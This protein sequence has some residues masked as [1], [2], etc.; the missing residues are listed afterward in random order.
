MTDASAQ[1]ADF[2]PF[3]RTIDALNK[4]SRTIQDERRKAGEA[5][6]ADFDM[7]AFASFSDFPVTFEDGNQPL[8]FVRALEN[9]FTTRN[10]HEGWWD[11]GVDKEIV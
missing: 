3:A 10:W 6:M 7:S 11:A 8:G 2:V 9:D 1:R 4:V 5:T